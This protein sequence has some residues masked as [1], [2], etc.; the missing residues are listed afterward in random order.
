MVCFTLPLRGLALVARSGAQ[1][2]RTVYPYSGAIEMLLF[3]C[4]VGCGDFPWSGCYFFCLV[5]GGGA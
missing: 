2:H 1:E 5:F 4:A 3:L